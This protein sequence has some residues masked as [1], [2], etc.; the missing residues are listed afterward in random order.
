[1]RVNDPSQNRFW[2]K[3]EILYRFILEEWVIRSYNLDS[4]SAEICLSQAEILDFRRKQLSVV[5]CKNCLIMIKRYNKVVLE[6]HVVPFALFIGNNCMFIY[7][8]ILDLTLQKQ[9]KGTCKNKYFPWML[10]L[11]D[12][13]KL[14]INLIRRWSNMAVIFLEAL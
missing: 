12:L 9:Y 3:T 1:M 13:A 7:V 10:N 2:A 8:K 11:K 6:E 4:C 5:M 14:W